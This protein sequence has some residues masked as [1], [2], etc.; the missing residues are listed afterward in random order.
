[1][2]TLIPQIPSAALPRTPVE[3]WADGLHGT[4]DSHH[5]KTPVDNPGPKVPGGWTDD[6]EP[7]PANPPN[8]REMLPTQDDVKRALESAKSYLPQGVASYLPSGSSDSTAVDVGHGAS[9]PYTESGAEPYAQG[10]ELGPASTTYTKSGAEPYGAGA[11]SDLGNSGIAGGS[12][13]AATLVAG[14]TTA[15][16]AAKQ[17][18]PESVA[19]YLPGSTSTSTAPSNDVSL[20]PAST[21]YTPAG[22]APYGSAAGASSDLGSAAAVTDRA[23][24]NDV[25][26]HPA[27]TNYTQAGPAPYGST[28]SSDLGSAAAAT[29]RTDSNTATLGHTPHPDAT[30]G[31]LP[32]HPGAAVSSAHPPHA[33]TH[34]VHPPTPTQ[35]TESPAPMTRGESVGGESGY[36]AETEPEM[37]IRRL[38]FQSSGRQRANGGP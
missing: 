31:I 17:Y 2:T 22:P 24:S 14:L 16:E 8:L 9:V 18:I 5:T 30:P 35:F 12:A 1:M 29:D 6:Q 19:A 28:A 7:L 37:E 27:S 36:V 34:P 21:T 26:L 38:Q 3:E 11:G 13:A 33:F 23:A 4:L 15:A 32:S 20:H 25:S 10:V